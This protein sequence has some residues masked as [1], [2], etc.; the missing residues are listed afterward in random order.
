MHPVIPIINPAGQIKIAN[1]K[2]NVPI[3]ATK[4]SLPITV[5]ILCSIAKRTKQNTD[6]INKKTNCLDFFQL[7]VKASIIR[8]LLIK[9]RMIPG[10]L[11]GILTRNA[12][13]SETK[14]RE[15]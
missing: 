13:R 14:L 4:L 9:L 7:C 10:G 8:I 3:P 5:K 1:R 15:R 12:Q 2:K 6:P 11:S